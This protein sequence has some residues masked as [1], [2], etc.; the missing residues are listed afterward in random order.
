MID[1]A[2]PNRRA[3]LGG[4]GGVALA[5]ATPLSAAP[6]RGF[7]TH[8]FGLNYVPSKGWYFCWNDWK[9]DNIERDFDAIAG[10]AADHIRIMLIWPYFQPNPTLVSPA[11]L[12]RLNQLMDLARGRGLDVL[13]TLYTGGLS[14]YRFRPPFYEKEPFYTSPIWRAAQRLLLDQTTARLVRHANFLGYDLGNEIEVCWPTDPATGDAWMRE[15]FAEME[16]AAPGRVHV[17]GISHLPLFQEANFSP[18]ALV[19]SQPIVAIHSWSFWADA[20]RYGGPLSE[21]YMRL[22][23]AMTALVR[24]YAQ[25]VDKPVWLEEFGACN[26]EMTDAQVEPWLERAMSYA[27]GEGVSWL[28]WWASHDV[29]TKL[30]FNKFEYDL[31]LLDID[32]RVKPRGLAFK[33]LAEAHRGK[34]VVRPRRLAAPPSGPRTMETTWAW[35]LDWMTQTA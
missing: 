18:Q 4:I 3:I 29:S 10:L 9:P 22:P 8:R 24:A 25:D 17:N 13:V 20:A 23:A 1:L 30:N 27:L 12:D 5:G 21:P 26:A 32:N 11:H 15:V 33:R 6:A 14:G 34:P 16:W 2:A 35:L 7:D 31:G 28:T 19:V